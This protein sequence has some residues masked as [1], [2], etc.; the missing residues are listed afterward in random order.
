M[1]SKAFIDKKLKVLYEDNDIVV[2][3]AP[4]EDELEHIV[5]EILKDHGRPLSVKE[6]HR[7]L[8][9]IA[10]EEKIRKTL[11]KLVSKN[12]VKS[13]TDGRYEWIADE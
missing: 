7:Y 2:V 11:Y 12:L 9:A 3:V 8:E 5:S 13:Y 10:S 6:I 4:H 1:G